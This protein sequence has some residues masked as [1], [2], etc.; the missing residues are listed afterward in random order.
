VC[1]VS[2]G[3]DDGGFSSSCSGCRRG[4]RME[5]SKSLGLGEVCEAQV[6]P[7]AEAEVE[8]RWEGHTAGGEVLLGRSSGQEEHWGPAVT[9]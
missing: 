3:S 5:I 1:G 4:C 9:A 8:F 2:T 7:E 6:P